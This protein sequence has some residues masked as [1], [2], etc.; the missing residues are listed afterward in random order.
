MTSDSPT[1]VESADLPALAALADRE[2]RAGRLAEATAAYRR[3]L[4]IRPDLAEAHNNLGLVL[5][6]QAERAQA[7]ASFLRALA[8]R[9]D[10]A[11]A[12]NN[13]GNALLAEGRL[14]EAAARYQQVIA[15]RP[16]QAEAYNSLGNIL[17]RQGRLVEAAAH[18][19]EPWPSSPTL[20]GLPT[21]WA[22]CFARSN[23]STKRRCATASPGGRSKTGRRP[24]QPGHRPVAPGQTGRGRRLLPPGAGSAAQPCQRAE[25]FGLPVAATSQIGR[26]STNLPT[27]G[28]ARPRFVPG[29]DGTGDLRF[30]RRKFSARLARL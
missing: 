4:A 30:D 20:P 21:T 1:P 15:L 18:S 3:L 8:L 27:P 24:P 12:H 25:P 17:R 5:W 22:T 7:V 28:R 2:H 10:L 26:S 29:G 13:L 16:G 6:R 11:D 23:G 14:D 19:S 9:P